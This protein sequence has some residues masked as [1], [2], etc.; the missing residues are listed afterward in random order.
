MLYRS[1]ESMKK[2]LPIREIFLFGLFL[3]LI[4]FLSSCATTPPMRPFEEW[5][6]VLPKNADVYFYFDNATVGGVVKGVLEEGKLLDRDTEFILSKTDKIY[7]AISIG[8]ES[9]KTALYSFITLGNYP[10]FF[11]DLNLSFK[12]K[13]KKKG[14]TNW[15]WFNK[16][17]NLE[18]AVPSDRIIAISNGRIERVLKNLNNPVNYSYPP[19]LKEDIRKSDI[20]VF[21]PSV[22]GNGSF[23]KYTRNIKIPISDVWFSLKR[24]EEN[25]ITSAVFVFGSEK[26][27]KLFA[28][29]F[30]LVLAA[31]LRDAKESN[32]GE[33]LRNVRVGVKNNT[34]FLSG[35]ELNSATIDEVFKNFGRNL[36]ESKDGGDAER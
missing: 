29:V 21:F 32:V 7:G 17:K 16:E 1:R 24:E 4:V 14:S 19:G 5:F 31:W 18:L 9:K 25:Y 2:S 6:A 27:A 30:K 23:K 34:M 28:F 22:T 12:G 33:K 35:L 36:K 20:V 10:K 15:Y 8:K 26:H 3:S 13:W 11:M